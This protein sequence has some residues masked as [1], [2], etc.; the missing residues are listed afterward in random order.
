MTQLQAQI[1]KPWGCYGAILLFLSYLSFF[2]A[3]QNLEQPG[4]IFTR[5]K[6]GIS[7]LCSVFLRGYCLTYRTKFTILGAF[8]DLSDISC[9]PSL[10]V[11]WICQQAQLS[12][13]PWTGHTLYPLNL[14]LVPPLL[15]TL[16]S[17]CITIKL[18]LF[19]RFGSN[20]P[21]F[22]EA[23][24]TLNIFNSFTPFIHAFL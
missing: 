2:K 21:F 10:P 18:L 23:F 12:V 14:Y 15:R 19:P 7:L 5:G 22:Y 24:L 4:I 6:C 13:V 1:V 3:F 17:F 8:K 20:V 11:G 16:S 9:Q